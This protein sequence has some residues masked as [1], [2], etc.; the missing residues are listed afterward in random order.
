MRLNSRRQVFKKYGSSLKIVYTDH[1]GNSKTTE[2][3]LTT[4]LKR[5]EKFNASPAVPFETLN[6]NLRSKSRLAENCNICNATT[7]IEKHH[8]K[9]HRMGRGV[10]NSFSQVM[11][12]IQRKQIP[13]CRECNMKMQRVENEGRSKKTKSK[14]ERV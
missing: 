2:M 7:E 5:I 3:K 8:V 6:N 10:D 9:S 14:S 12:N 1:K 11:I 13:V 4:T